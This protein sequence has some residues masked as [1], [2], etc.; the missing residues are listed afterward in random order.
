MRWASCIALLALASCKH[1]H[2]PTP[3]EN[4][5]AMQL[6]AQVLARVYAKDAAVGAVTID[7]SGDVHVGPADPALVQAAADVQHRHDAL[8]RG[9]PAHDIA[10]DAARSHLAL[11]VGDSVAKQCRERWAKHQIAI[12]TTMDLDLDAKQVSDSALGR[13]GPVQ[14]VRAT[15]AGCELRFE[16][17]EP[18]YGAGLAFELTETH[19]RVTGMMW[20]WDSI[21]PRSCGHGFHVAGT[22]EPAAP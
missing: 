6:E 18:D 8:L 15:A 1:E 12:T 16:L 3:E 4:E 20:Y 2:E 7:P 5:Q 13:T 19:G 17:L 14:Q 10:C 9:G 22:R 21:T 11:A